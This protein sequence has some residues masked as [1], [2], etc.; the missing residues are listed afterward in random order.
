M[1]FEF[2]QQKWDVLAKV[3]AQAL[4]FPTQKLQKYYKMY[5]FLLLS[6]SHV[7]N[8]TSILVN[9]FCLFVHACQVCVILYLD[10]DSEWGTCFHS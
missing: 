1:V 7:D 8:L 9:D 6:I 5:D 4:R 3:Y 2:S 10:N